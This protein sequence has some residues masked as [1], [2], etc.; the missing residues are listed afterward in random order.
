MFDAEANV[1]DDPRYREG[2]GHMQAARWAKAI[3]CFLLLT[4][5][6]P[7][8]ALAQHALGEAQ[9]KAD[10]DSRT[11]V[12]PVTVG[13]GVAR[14]W[15]MRVALVLVL[16]VVVWQGLP[17]VT[18][19]LVPAIRTMQLT[20][21]VNDLLAAGNKALE[22]KALDA[23]E[24]HYTGILARVG[25]Y[26]VGE[27]QANPFA[28]Q[29]SVAEDGLQQI[30]F[31]RE[32]AALYEQGLLLQEQGNVRAALD[33]MRQVQA[34][35]PDYQDVAQRVA[36]MSRAVDL[37]DLFTDAETKRQAGLYVEALQAYLNIRA[38][39]LSY[40]REMVTSRLF[41][42]Y[43]AAGKQVMRTAAPERDVREVYAEAQTYFREALSLQPRSQEVAD[44]QALAE[45]YQAAEKV[46]Y[47]AQW[48]DAVAQLGAVY[49]AAPDYLGGRLVEM[50]YD[51]L[52][53]RADEL[54]E[55]GDTYGAYALYERAAGLPASDTSLAQAGKAAI[56]ALALPTPTRSPT[57]VPTATPVPTARPTGASGPAAGP[58]P[59]PTAMPLSA[60]RGKIVFLSDQPGQTGLWVMG[61][62]GSGRQYL[63]NSQELY[64]QH[65]QLVASYRYA[66]S[67]QRAFVK[68]DEGGIAQIWV[69]AA[70]GERQVT[71]LS[72]LCYDPA[73]SPNGTQIVFVSEAS[74]SDDIWVT[75]A[76]SGEPADL[77]PAIG[78]WEKHPSWSPDGS[79]IVFWSSRAG[80][81]QIYTMAAVVG[82]AASNIS[83]TTWNEYDPVW[84][85]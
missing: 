36:E 85:R 2:L 71:R 67:G 47:E 62:D 73:W 82:A 52:V 64:T 38:T 19:R 23:A 7:D 22:A 83:N 39:N 54:R 28:R 50:L 55:A 56:D 40:R 51:A 21:E 75:Y 66:P 70:G 13:S 49:D 16:A 4:R 72:G 57:A 76:E 29:V 8:S 25:H 48:A 32:I 24:E 18:N 10:L 6:Y 65:A 15:V 30:A 5:D 34:R 44:E 37:E 1:R 78:S 12:R 3:E 17:L 26:P 80:P 61:P 63:G 53:R 41:E 9:F 35:Y 68:N 11:S 81:Q 79:R 42:L 77:T 69:T 74:G 84:V 46:Y 20:R 43:L 58:T 60:Y 45:A 14:K 31:Q 59:T 33:A 27:G